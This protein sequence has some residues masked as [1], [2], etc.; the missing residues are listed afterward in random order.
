MPSWKK[1]LASGSDASFS[2]VSVDTFVSASSFKG[3]FTGSLQGTSSQSISSSY[4]QTASY[5]AG[6]VSAFPYSGSAQITGSLGVTGSLIVTG[7]ILQNGG[8][9]AVQDGTILYHTI[10]WFSPTS[11]ISTTGSTVNIGS[12]QFTFPMVGAKLTISGESR[13]ITTQNSTSQV[14][15]DTPYSQNYSN[16]ASGSW[17]V[18]RKCVQINS[19][20]T[21]S[22]TFANGN[23]S[24]SDYGAIS[25][26]DVIRVPKVIGG[27]SSVGPE[28]VAFGVQSNV[29]GLALGSPYLIQWSSGS[30]IDT[31]KDL[32]LRRNTGSLLEIYNGVTADGTLA[33][34]A[35]LLVRNI[36]GSNAT[37]SGSLAVS[38]SS[39]I[40]GSLNVSQGITGSLFGTASW[41]TNF[42]TGSVTSAS[43]A[44]TASYALNAGG[45][46]SSITI[47]TAGT[48]QGTAS[49]FN[50][51]NAVSASFNSA[52]ASF[53]ITN[54]PLGTS[55]T[56]TQS[57]AANTWSFSHGVGSRTPIVQAYDNNYDQII[58]TRI[59]SPTPFQTNLYFDVAELGYAIIS[60]G[61]TVT[62]S[63]S[64]SILTQASPATT[65]SFNHNLGTKYPV[66]TI[67]DASDNVIVPQRI[68]AQ[69]S[70]SAFVYFSSPTA[71]RAV[72]ALG[73][74]TNNTASFAL[75]ASYV[76]NA[77][78][79]S[80]ALTASY[81]SGSSISSISAS[82]A[83]NASASLIAVSASYAATASYLLGYISPFPFTGSAQITGSLGVTGSINSTGNIT[84]TGTLTAQTLVVQTITSSIEYSSGSNIFG[85][86]L[87]DRQTFTGSVNITGSIQLTGDITSSGNLQLN[88]GLINLGSGNGIIRFAGNNWMTTNSTDAR[89]YL[90]STAQYFR[91]YAASGT[92]ITRL[93][94]SGNWII[95][96]GGTFTDN[97][98]KL[99]LQGSGS[100]S[101]SLYSNGFSVFDGTISGSQPANNVSSSLILISGSI[102]PTGS[103]GTGSV[104]LLNT[105]MSASANNQTLVGLDLNP[106]FNTGSFTGVTNYGVRIQKTALFNDTW[107]NTQALFGSLNQGGRIGFID[108]Y[109]G[110]GNGSLGFNSANTINPV[111]TLT[112][113][114][115]GLTL[116]NTGGGTTTLSGQAQ[117]VV[118]SSNNSLGPEIRATGT[119]ARILINSQGASGTINFNTSATQNAQVFSTGNWLLQQG[120]TFTDAG[121]K[122]DVNGT[123]RMQSSLSVSQSLF[124]NQNTASLGS[125]TQTV[126]TN[127][128]SSYTSAFYRYSVVSGSN[129]RAGEFIACW[130]GS[131]VQY[132]DYSTTDIGNTSLVSFTASLSAGNVVLTTV[133]P[134]SGWNINT[135]VNLL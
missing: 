116:S 48:T 130:N 19:N 94:S 121:Y 25:L 43:Y 98:Y 81:V 6:Y 105:V 32:G 129:A 77:I 15:V 78:S 50:F 7:S 46:L 122:L 125:S 106:T 70:A 11:F 47:A 59:F 99:Q 45:G 5:L 16:V 51:T 71:G 111:L 35:D 126:S 36:T 104:V 117:V 65:W 29:S 61:G 75:T 85:S 26:T 21:L 56:F 97:G 14:L 112:T 60:T 37:F 132:T 39:S 119:V 114:A 31:G 92:E 28:P 131:S 1:V 95:Q 42:I 90:Q 96:N 4:A 34:R 57:I 68:F 22:F 54:T 89:F 58:P 82:Y 124:T 8:A 118:V 41:A 52:T 53:F 72:A 103:A 86:Q 135:L 10:Q 120:G 127:S 87:T 73:G 44:Q 55:V 64:N 49:Y 63:G 100:V 91:W 84:T 20:G 133:L 115:G 12:T 123:A 23:W 17:G 9:L 27:V 66:F 67:F 3:S 30:T 107:A 93:Y 13:I 33:N 110:S 109:N 40:T 24:I 102:N 101:G 69:D 80:Y 38:G 79:S 113:N 18:Y 108:G 2:S 128:T 62:A 83:T 74:L 134:S 88:S 76:V